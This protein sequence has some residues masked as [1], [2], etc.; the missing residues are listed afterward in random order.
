MTRKGAGPGNGEASTCTTCAHPHA[1]LKPAASS[2]PF[3][4]LSRSP[5]GGL[6]QLLGASVSVGPWSSHFKAIPSKLVSVQICMF[7]RVSLRLPR[8]FLSLLG[9]VV[10]PEAGAALDGSSHPSVS[11]APK[12][13]WNAGAQQ[14][15]SL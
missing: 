4:R 10:Q 14:W 9:R 5:W 13:S 1:S 3:L 2:S 12:T 6:G 11:V 8:G 15:P 7:W